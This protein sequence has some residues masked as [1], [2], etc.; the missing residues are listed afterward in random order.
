MDSVFLVLS[1]ASPRRLRIRSGDFDHGYFQGERFSKPLVLCQPHGGLP[2]PK[3]K[4]GDRMLAFVPIYGIRDAGRGLW[5]S[6][7]RVSAHEGC[8]EDFLMPAL[9]SL[10][11]KGVLHILIA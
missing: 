7:R 5:R 1:F 3:V 9:F 4:P 11:I 6:I 10:S 8:A 2:D